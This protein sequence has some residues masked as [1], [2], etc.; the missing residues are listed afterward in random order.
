MS[1]PK[2]TTE[3]TTT[4]TTTAK[5]TKESDTITTTK[6]TEDTKTTEATTPETLSKLQ[7]RI[8]NMHRSVLQETDWLTDST[9]T[10]LSAV[11]GSAVP[12]VYEVTIRDGVTAIWD[13]EAGKDGRYKLEFASGKR[14]GMGK[15]H[16]IYVLK[17]KARPGSYSV[18]DKLA[19]RVKAYMDLKASYAERVEARK[20]AHKLGRKNR[21]AAWLK[22]Q[23]SKTGLPQGFDIV[24]N[25]PWE[26]EDTI[27]LTRK[28]ED[29][30]IQLN[31]SYTE[32]TDKVKSGSYKVAS[33]TFSARGPKALK[34]LLA[35]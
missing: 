31:V 18:P 29:S 33:G 23:K 32:P 1:K 28:A 5:A 22:F 24:G 17:A 14:F 34:I 6:T 2:T 20:A 27:Y 12:F 15:E 35:L 9:T 16:G 25:D 13:I 11:T 19:E 8:H 21:K 26:T 10:P 4:K 7:T 3:D 30:T